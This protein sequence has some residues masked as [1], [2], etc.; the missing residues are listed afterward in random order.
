ME[1]RSKYIPPSKVEMWLSKNHMVAIKQLMR[2]NS[3]Y[4]G[5]RNTNSKFVYVRPSQTERSSKNTKNIY[6]ALMDI[7]PSWQGWPRRSRSV[8]CSDSTEYAGG[9][10]GPSERW[11]T[12]NSNLGAL[13]VVLPKDGSKIGVCPQQD[14]WDSFD[15]I[16][17][18]WRSDNMN[19]FNESFDNIFQESYK[20]A[21]G[22][23]YYNEEIGELNGEAMDFFLHHIEGVI[24]PVSLRR[25]RDMVNYDLQHEIEDMLEYKFGA[26]KSWIEYFDDLLNPKANRFQLQTIEK[27]SPGVINS[28]IDMHEVWTESDCLFIRMSNFNKNLTKRLGSDY[29]LVKDLIK[30]VT[31]KDVNIGRDDDI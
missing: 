26:K 6:T 5:L 25:V 1:S 24:T 10:T 30:K 21:T 28:D 22:D 11:S 7:L 27:Y 16:K 9:Y 19:M 15:V 14:I 12:D 3:I 17:E 31:E 29:T 4:R 20:F 23:D 2:G 13:Y 18:R 8:I